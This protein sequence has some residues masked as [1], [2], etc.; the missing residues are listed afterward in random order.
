MALLRSTKCGSRESGSFGSLVQREA[1]RQST[2][3]EPGEGRGRG[4]EGR[5]GEGRGGEEGE[6]R[7][8]GGVV[9]VY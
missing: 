5:G 3:F 4:G 6:G 7:G 8:G 2:S 9:C 1:M